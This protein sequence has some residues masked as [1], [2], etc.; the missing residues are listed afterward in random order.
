MK[1]SLSLARRSARVLV[2]AVTSAAMVS[3]CQTT[4]TS[5]YQV[6]SDSCS[7]YRMPMV[8]VLQTMEQPI[9]PG[10]VLG[11]ALLGAAVGAVA[12]GGRGSAIA[13]G[14]L[15]G[16][17]T[18][19]AASYYNSRAKVAKSQA[20]LIA[21]IDNDASTDSQRYST[22]GSSLV[23]LSACRNKQISDLAMSVRSGQIS[24][25]NAVQMRNEIQTA[26]KLDGELIDKVVGEVKGRS[27]IYVQARLEAL[28][29]SGERNPTIAPN[30]GTQLSM[31]AATSVEQQAE[32]AKRS[33]ETNLKGLDAL[34]S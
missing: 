32:S 5:R 15:A 21:A 23:A 24:K 13:A 20:E 4:D 6:A 18:G 8:Q 25:A 3:G 26:V 28:R 1:A 14:A 27:D 31:S 2:V 34:L 30:S 33:T 7:Q 12:G 9:S 22:V 29:K 16:A 17:L 11:A 10:V 19:A